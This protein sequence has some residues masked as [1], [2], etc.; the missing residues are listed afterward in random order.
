MT[1]VQGSRG[2]DTDES[3][4]ADSSAAFWLA[5]PIPTSTVL[6]VDNWQ[7]TLTGPG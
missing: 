3:L 1:G 6:A 7:V 4:P 5:E 2:D